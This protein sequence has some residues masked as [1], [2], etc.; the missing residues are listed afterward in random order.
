MLPV[1][2]PS[3]THPKLKNTFSVSPVRHA[4]MANMNVVRP[5]E[6]WIGTRDALNPAVAPSQHSKIKKLKKPTTNC[7]QNGV[8]S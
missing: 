8:G 1:R 7:E 2:P 6:A 4:A 5:K 3:N